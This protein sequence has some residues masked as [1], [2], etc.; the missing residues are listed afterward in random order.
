M[1][2][3]HDSSPG[4]QLRTA[5]L[6]RTPGRLRVLG[7]LQEARQ[8]L[9][10]ADLERVLTTDAHQ[11]LDRVTL[12]RVLDSLVA[13]GLALKAV[14]AHGVYRYSAAD[15]RQ[16]HEGHLHFRCVDCGG[17]FCLDE[18]PPPPPKLPNGFR[19]EAVGLDVSGVCAKCDLKGHPKSDEDSSDR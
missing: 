5:G 11:G 15:A 14:D 4:G 9:S 1:E 13:G 7:A 16:R 17:V 18:L 6:K 10:H 19:L 8:P 3:S 12:Y 2:R